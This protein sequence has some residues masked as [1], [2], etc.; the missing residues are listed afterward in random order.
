MSTQWRNQS[1]N[2]QRC[3]QVIVRACYQGK[4]IPDKFYEAM[5]IFSQDEIEAIEAYVACK[6]YGW[7]YR[8]EV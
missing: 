6:V 5:K 3:G 7:K 8:K 2:V 1:K 4:E